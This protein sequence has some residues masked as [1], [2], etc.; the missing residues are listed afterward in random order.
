MHLLMSL[1]VV[2]LLMIKDFPLWKA[3]YFLLNLNNKIEAN[4][5]SSNLFYVKDV[6]VLLLAII[7]P[8]SLILL[9]GFLI[10]FKYS[11]FI[12]FAQ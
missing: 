6:E 2:F 8:L 5:L 1:Q 3:E 9:E 7:F 12:D 4:C 11:F 10:R